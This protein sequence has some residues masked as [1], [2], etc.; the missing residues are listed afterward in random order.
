MDVVSL[1]YADAIPGAHFMSNVISSRVHALKHE[2]N[3]IKQIKGCAV[4]RGVVDQ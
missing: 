3:F 1:F 2:V 4:S